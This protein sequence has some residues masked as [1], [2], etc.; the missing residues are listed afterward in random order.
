ML[1]EVEGSTGRVCE[2]HKTKNT[3]GHCVI[4]RYSRIMMTRLS[5]TCSEGWKCSYSRVLL[6]ISWLAVAPGLHGVEVIGHRGDG[7][8]SPENTLAAFK[9][10][11]GVATIAE[12]DVH[13]TKDGVLVLMHDAT[14]D[15]TTDGTGLVSEMTVEELKLLDAGSWRGAQF[16]GERIPTLREA[17]EDLVANGI[18]PLIERKAGRAE[19]FVETLAGM[20]DKV[21]VQS[22]DWDFLTVLHEANALL[23]LGGLASGE[24]NSARLDFAE[25]AGITFLAWFEGDIDA[26]FIEA[27]RVRNMDIFAYT[28]N[29]QAR[30]QQLIDLEVDGVITDFPAIFKEI[31]DSQPEGPV[32]GPV[33]SLP[34]DDGIAASSERSVTE[35]VSG[36]VGTFNTTERKFGSALNLA[37][38]G[39]SIS[40]SSA[41]AIGRN[42]VTIAT[43]VKLTRLPSEEAASFAGIYDSVEDGYV[44]Y[45]DRNQSELRF[46][47]TD[48]DGTAERPGITEASLNTTEWLHIAGVYN[49]DSGTASIFLNGELMDQHVNG[50]LN[51]RVRDDQIAA[52]GHNGVQ[53]SAFKFDGLID[54]FCIWDIPL[55]ADTVLGV[56]ESGQ[57][58]SAMPE[59]QTGLRSYF[60]F[61][62]LNVGTT[63]SADAIASRTATLSGSLPLT[64]WSQA[65]PL[66][67]FGGA[68]FLDGTVDYV[69]PPPGGEFNTSGNALTLS[70]WVRLTKL[71]SE[72]R[73]PFGGIYDSVEDG[74]V[75]YL[76]RGSNELRFKVTDTDGTAERPGI[77]AAQLSKEEWIHVTGVYDG[78]EGQAS[79]YK[80]GE[81]MDRH[82]NGGLTGVVRAQNATIGRNG[83]ESR[84]YFIG[85]IDDMTLWNRALEDDEIASLAES[86]LSAYEWFAGQGSFSQWI[87]AL[88]GEGGDLDP[89]GDY[90]NNGISNLEEY[91][92]GS[93]VIGL[94]VEDAWDGIASVSQVRRLADVS[95]D[96]AYDIE[97]STD[98]Q[99]W[100]PIGDSPYSFNTETIWTEAPFENRRFVFD[101]DWSTTDE[102]F[103]RSS[104]SLK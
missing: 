52:F 44:L 95:A 60:D 17:V 4:V 71:P 65:P 35:V 87:L 50:G 34:F 92:Y 66:A 41:F 89:A 26:S 100:Q 81:L 22:F 59:L 31:V 38:G 8:N 85:G 56:Y 36:A 99:T 69:D 47:V 76:D 18:T 3:F 6:L 30:M 84:S 74:F 39:A 58:V 14:V 37:G 68:I 94:T 64:G 80:N 49:G 24:L 96:I 102:I 16:A 98:L 101:I 67:K 61:E 91:A 104:V 63:T 28:V 15:R 53:T 25:S 93:G 55:S 5:R 12:L 10:I 21:L 78:A 62:D 77:P 27:A 13:E 90:N 32:Y 23:K 54:D 48:E 43:W 42:S 83:V 46:K 51:G 19:L 29:N 97:V 86:S 73:E 79:I 103:F 1:S 72:I 11:R 82:R 9:A 7:V 70:A 20:E 57:P 45:L 88:A 75:L 33:A 2:S 40:N